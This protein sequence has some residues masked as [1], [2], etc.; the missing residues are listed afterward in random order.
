MMSLRLVKTGTD[1]LTSADANL[2]SSQQEINCELAKMTATPNP[3]INDGKTP[4]T[5]IEA[6]PKDTWDGGVFESITGMSVD[7][8]QDELIRIRRALEDLQRDSGGQAE[9]NAQMKALAATV[10]GELDRPGLRERIRAIETTMASWNQVITK[11]IMPIAVLVMGSG[12][13]AACATLWW[14]RK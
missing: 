9:I 6:I 1:A 5:L 10:Y 2:T 14:V 8:F 11:V 4:W 12:I 3:Y 13:L 7:D